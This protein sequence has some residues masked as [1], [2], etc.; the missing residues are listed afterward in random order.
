MYPTTWNNS[1]FQVHKAT[2]DWYSEFDN[3][4]IE[5]SVK[6]KANVI[7]HE[8]ID[9]VRNSLTPFLRYDLETNQPDGLQSFVKQYLIGRV[10]TRS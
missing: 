3:W 8:G 6:T 9:Y 2:K 7:W 5:G 10:E 1:W 4:F